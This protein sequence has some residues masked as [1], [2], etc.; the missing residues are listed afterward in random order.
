[1]KINADICHFLV[2][3]SNT[4]KLKIRNIDITKSKSKKLLGAEFD[5]ELSFDDHI[6]KLRKKDSRKIPGASFI[7]FSKR[8]TLMNAFFK[9]QFSY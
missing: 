5:H 8:R 1:M 4:V 3:T 7:N 6:S 2:S 9:S